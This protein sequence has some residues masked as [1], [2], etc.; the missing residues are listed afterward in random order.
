M[1]FVKISVSKKKQTKILLVGYGVVVAVVVITL[2]SGALNECQLYCARS[3][4]GEKRFQVL[5]VP[6]HLV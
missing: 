5:P 6:L 3:L 4:P 1:I 2:S